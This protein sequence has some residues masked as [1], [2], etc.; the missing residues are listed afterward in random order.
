MLVNTFRARGIGDDRLLGGRWSR[1]SGARFGGRSGRRCWLWAAAAVAAA[2]C[3]AA[4]AAVQLHPVGVILALSISCPFFA[5]CC[6]IPAAALVASF[7]ALLI[8]NFR[9]IYTFANVSPGKTLL[10]LISTPVII[11]A[12]ATRFLTVS[13]HVKGI[14]LAFAL[15]GPLTASVVSFDAGVDGGLADAARLATVLPHPHGFGHAV[16]VGNV[17]GAIVFF[18]FTLDRLIGAYEARPWTIFLHEALIFASAFSQGHPICA[19]PLF[20]EA[21]IWIHSRLEGTTSS[22]GFF[23]PFQHE[24]RV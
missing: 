10:I 22:T 24:I 2:A 13:Q 8:H 17:S 16:P 23:A 12:D 7:P 15:R 4:L 14:F 5:T 3:A 1:L 20:V 21:S 19:F 11:V 6:I 9:L 18:I